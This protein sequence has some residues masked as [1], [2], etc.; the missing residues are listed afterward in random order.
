MFGI[1]RFILAFLVLVTHIGK[2]EIYGGFAVWGFFMLSGFLITGVLNRRYGFTKA[3]LVEFGWSRALRLYPTYWLSTILAFLAVLVSASSIN[4]QTINNALAIPASLF[5]RIAGFF[6]AG[7]TLL[8]LGRVGLALSPSVWAVDVEMLLYVIS[9]VWLSRAPKNSSRAI[10]VCTLLFPL[11]WLTGKILM[12]QG[13]SEIAQQMTYSFLPAALLPYGIGAWLWFYKRRFQNF[14][15]N[16]SWLLG[17]ALMLIVCAS[18]LSRISITL[19]YLAALPVMALITA[20]LANLDLR[21]LK[22]KIDDLFGH[23]SYSIY[24][25]HWT[26]ALLVAWIFPRGIASTIYYLNKEG[27]VVFTALG[28]GL[29]TL[30]TLLLSVLIAIGFEAPI[31]RHRRAFAKRLAMALV[32][33]VWNPRRASL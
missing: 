29:D 1:Y 14:K 3:G 11:C 19:A 30:V 2:V 32:G 23:M 31:E 4:P 18:G 5:D 15:P 25:T 13:Q 12:R 17:C 7:N 33:R 26:C 6:I 9:A 24:L 27:M 10:V 8:G 22:K 16:K 20:M 21:G 28:F